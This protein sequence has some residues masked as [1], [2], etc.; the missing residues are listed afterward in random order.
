MG[1]MKIMGL[2]IQISY[3]CSSIC[4]LVDGK[5]SGLAV[6]RFIHIWE[7]KTCSLVMMPDKLPRQTMPGIFVA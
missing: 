2:F 5:R 6:V 4:F 7:E 3:L 1:F